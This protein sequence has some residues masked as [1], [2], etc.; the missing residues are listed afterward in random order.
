MNTNT[1]NEQGL[2]ARLFRHR[3][4]L[5]GTLILCTVI[6]SAALASNL[7][8]QDPMRIVASP[9]LWPMQELAHPLGT[10]AMGR[11]IAALVVHGAR[12]SLLI[13][14]FAALTATLIGVS[15]GALAAYY[16]GWVDE[17]V[18]RSAEL[19][20]TIPNLIF[21]LSIVSILGPTLTHITLAIGFV[22][23]NGIAR[24]TRAEFLSLKERDFVNACR[25]CGM[26]D[27]RIIVGEILPNALPPVV[28][29]SSLTVASAILFESAISFLGL[30]DA[31]LASWGR[32]IGDGRNL[33][34]T[35]WYICA[36]PGV[37]IMLTVLA[38]NLVGDGL[39]DALN[40]K[41]R[42]R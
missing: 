41:L 3:G 34:R 22:S 39:N 32:M 13:G 7:F 24:L 23:W 2:L 19:F 20:Q 27:M 6:G 42:S 30:G 8:P 26:A 40:P 1:L 5:I 11:D 33:I 25:A 12:A 36:V 16:G 28:V 31:N 38:L 21:L 17:L 18:M 14:V 10:D 15:V 29:L 37:A 4:A 35:S 9:E